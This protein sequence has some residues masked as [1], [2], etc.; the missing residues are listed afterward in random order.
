MHTSSVMYRY[1]FC[2]RCMTILYNVPAVGCKLLDGFIEGA[3]RHLQS[4][5]MDGVNTPHPMTSGR[6]NPVPLSP[7]VSRSLPRQGLGAP[8]RLGEPQYRYGVY[9]L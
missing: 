6:T 8:S 2:S 9:K 7:T 1:S 4:G 3:V 5:R